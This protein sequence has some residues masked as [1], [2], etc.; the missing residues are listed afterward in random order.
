MAQLKRGVV[1]TLVSGDEARNLSIYSVPL[2][3]KYA[4]RIKADFVELNPSELEYSRGPH[5]EKFQ[6]RQL[7]E[8]YERVIFFDVD[9]LITPHAPNLF[10]VVNKSVLGVVNVSKIFNSLSNE[11]SAVKQV[12]N[13]ELDGKQYFNSGVMVVSQEQRSLFDD[14]SQQLTKWIDAKKRG[15]RCLNDQTY[16]NYYAQYLNVTLFNLGRAY[17]Y[18]RAWGGF[19]KKYQKYIIHYAGLKEVRGQLMKR[20]SMV[21]SNATLF[22]LFSTFPFITYTFDRVSHYLLRPITAVWLRK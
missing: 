5:Y 4:T 2:M 12:F 21:I 6:I 19:H 11:I 17:N 16:L 9:T 7:L 3:K 15:L 13:F 8:K 18:T 1:C 20:D 10:N 22:N 14:K